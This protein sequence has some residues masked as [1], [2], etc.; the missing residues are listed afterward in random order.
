MYEPTSAS[1][2]KLPLQSHLGAEASG[3]GVFQSGKLSQQFAAVRGDQ[4]SSGGRCCRSSVGDEIG[5]GDI[6]LVAD[7][8]HHRNGRGGN[9]PRY[10][11]KIER[12]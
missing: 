1:V 4:F 6:R 11:F 3:E 12:G 7:G 2:Q 9:A 5:D 8:G 10:R